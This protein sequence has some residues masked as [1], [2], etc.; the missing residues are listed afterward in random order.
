[1]T[2]PFP[3]CLTSSYRSLGGIEKIKATFRTPTGKVYGPDFIDRGD[4]YR[5]EGLRPADQGTDGGMSAMFKNMEDVRE[6]LAGDRNIYAVWRWPRWF[7][8]PSSWASPSSVEGPAGVGKTDLGKVIAAA[9]DR[10]V[11]PAAV[12]RRTGRIEIPLRMGVLQTAPLHPDTQGRPGPGTGWGRLTVR[13]GGAGG[14][15]GRGLLLT[16][17]RSAPAPAPRHPLERNRP[18]CLI[19][20]VD[21]SDPEFEA[22]L[23]EVPLRFPGAPSPRSAPWWPDTYPWSS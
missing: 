6:G 1:M 3:S 18:S 20:E 13:S 10:E 22:F 11:H 9:L 4:R 17:V 14:P 7:T 21:K 19:D 12:L 2:S 15:A 5:V 8:W 23:L 16:E